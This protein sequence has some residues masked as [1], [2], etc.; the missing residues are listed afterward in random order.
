MAQRVYFDHSA[1][2]PLVP[3]HF[4]R[5]SPGPQDV[6]I[7]ILYCG[8]CHTDLHQ[9]RNDWATRSTRWCL[10]TRLSAVSPPLARR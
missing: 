3:F 8:V 6:Q 2:T 4:E 5:R 7:E 1:T 9:V 10:A